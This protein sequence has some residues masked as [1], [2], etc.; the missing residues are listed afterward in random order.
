[1]RI[2][3]FDSWDGR[4][5]GGQEY[6]RSV[7]DELRRRGHPQRLLSAVGDP[8]YE[9]RDDEMVFPVPSGGLRRAA[10]DLGADRRFREWFGREVE[11]FRPDLIHLHHYEAEFTALG[12]AVAGLTVPV[13]FTAHDAS[14]VCPISTLIRP[15]AVVC[16]GGVLPRCQTTG[17]RVGLGLP[18]NLVQRRRFDRTVAPR[19]RAYLCPST[20]LV[21]YLETNGYSPAVHLPPFAV[22]PPDVRSAPYPPSAPDRESVVGYIGRL[23]E[24]KGVRD[25]LHAYAVLRG[26]NPSMR[27]SIAGEGPARAP[28]EALA[29][30]LGVSDGVDWVGH[31]R[32]GEKESWFRS[33]ATVA[34]PSSA[35]E[36]F[37]LVALE[38]LTRG[39]PVVATEFGGLPDIVQDRESGRLVPVGNPTQLAEGIADVLSDPERAQK[40]AL[41]GR[42]RCLARFTPELHVDR[43]LAVYA[44]TLSGLKFA[45]RSRAADLV[46]DATPN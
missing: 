21:E 12:R 7:A 36:N 15:G 43:L 22:I 38:A 23:E 3:R 39:R 17:C 26:Q 13:L 11:A 9:P 16:E 42:E 6:V 1:M 34:V 2:L 19:I 14:L 24:Y 31:V 5:G 30:S 46:G 28:L 18:Y 4:S 40:W 27:L 8:G 41:T 37:G 29:R 25:L 33:V 45:P 44:R 10:L 32:G 35:W 20:R